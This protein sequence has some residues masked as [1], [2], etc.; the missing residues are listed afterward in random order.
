[1]VPLIQDCFSL[2]ALAPC[3]PFLPD[4]PPTLGDNLRKLVAIFQGS[5]LQDHFPEPGVESGTFVDK[6]CSPVLCTVSQPH[7]RDPPFLLTLLL[8]KP[9]V[10][11]GLLIRLNQAGKIVMG[12]HREV[13]G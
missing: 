7:F 10:C 4:S 9:F 6:G 12:R 3:L 5:F 2:G 13:E 1:M 11:L 8:A